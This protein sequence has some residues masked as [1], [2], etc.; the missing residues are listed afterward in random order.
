M[1]TP[2]EGEAAGGR[3]RVVVVDDDDDMRA[4]LGD[5]IAGQPALELV[6]AGASADDAVALARSRRP[7]VAVLD[8]RMPGGGPSAALRIAECCPGTAVVA[9]SAHA[10]ARSVSLMTE[11]GAMCYL[12]KGKSSMDEIVGAIRRAGLTR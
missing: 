12:V 2:I 3:V 6:G 5:V 11:A 1:A 10:D 7:D 8:V 9:L 4:A